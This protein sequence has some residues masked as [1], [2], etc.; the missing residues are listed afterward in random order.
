MYVFF[1]RGRFWLAV[2]M[3]VLSGCATL[4]NSIALPPLAES[5]PPDCEVTLRLH[6][7]GQLWG[8][9]LIINS[10]ESCIKKTGEDFVLPPNDVY[11]SLDYQRGRNS[12][13]TLDQLCSHVE[14]SVSDKPQRC[15]WNRQFH[16]A[17]PFDIT[18]RSVNPTKNA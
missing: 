12:F 4:N 15:R 17:Y 7:Q 2:I 8:Q 16:S 6:Y 18:I 14:S 1:P 13:R 9:K 11:L 3:S 10:Q 5:V